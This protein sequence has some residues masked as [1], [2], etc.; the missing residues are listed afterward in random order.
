MIATQRAPNGQTHTETFPPF[1]VT[2]TIKIKSQE[3]FKLNKINHIIIK[4]ELYK[5]RLALCSATTAKT[6]AMSDITANNPLDACGVVVATYIGNALKRRIQLSMSSCCNC[7][8]H[9]TQA[10]A[11]RKNC[12]GEEDNELPRDPLGG[13]SLSSPHQSSSTQLQCVK[14]YITSNHRHSRQMA[15]R[16]RICHNRKFRE[17]VCQ[18]RL[19]VRQTMTC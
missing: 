1:L 18:Y 5:P 17:Q 16:M 12:K 7:T 14:T 13:C 15:K 8:Q 11:M 10:A 2:L 9:H 6:L 19:P 3:T 4:V